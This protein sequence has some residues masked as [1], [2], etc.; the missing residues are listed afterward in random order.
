MLNIPNSKSISLKFLKKGYTPNIENMNFSK[1]VFKNY[2]VL[3]R[4][5]VASRLKVKY[6]EDSQIIF[7]EWLSTFNSIFVSH[8]FLRCSKSLLTP[9]PTFII[10]LC[11]LQL[12]LMKK[13]ELCNKSLENDKIIKIKNV[14]EF[15]EQ[16]MNINDRK[17]FNIYDVAIYKI[18]NMLNN[19]KNFFEKIYFFIKKRD[20]DKKNDKSY[21]D[22]D[23]NEYEIED[24]NN[25]FKSL[26][27]NFSP[28]N[29]FE[30]SH[31]INDYNIKMI[32]NHLKPY[33]K[34]ND[35][36]MLVEKFKKDST[37]AIAVCIFNIDA[38]WKNGKSSFAGL[39]NFKSHGYNEMKDFFVFEGECRIINGNDIEIISIPLLVEGSENRNLEFVMIRPLDGVRYCAG[40][41]KIGEICRLINIELNL[42]EPC[43]CK[44]LMPVIH[45][46]IVDSLENINFIGEKTL[47]YS[48]TKSATFKNI[49]DSTN[50]DGLYYYSSLFINKNGIKSNNNNNENKNNSITND[51]LLKDKKYNIRMD[52]PFHYAILDRTSKDTILIGS[53]YGNYISNF[54]RI[55]TVE[56]LKKLNEEK[57]KKRMNLLKN[58]QTEKNYNCCS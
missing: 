15:L 37:N 30:Y 26:L 34:I 49:Y 16:V 31:N 12:S 56:N 48:C 38:K 33:I 45:S 5:K 1:S 21:N 2:Y 35:I 23:D 25:D 3:E 40:L 50:L 18:N 52:I 43:Q 44:I 4:D 57:L 29:T 39:H 10:S 41:K 54:Q 19:K 28:K 14:D 42:I 13:K 20:N 46:P 11:L 27:L 6:C 24:E 7:I 47:F 51:N 9:I 8:I 53:Y 58:T 36:N 22:S 32:I 55:I 17:K